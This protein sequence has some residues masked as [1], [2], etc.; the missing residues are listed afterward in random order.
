VFLAMRRL[1]SSSV[2][3]G[4]LPG[5]L[6]LTDAYVGEAFFYHLLRLVYVAAVNDQWG[7]HGL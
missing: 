2:I 6:L 3:V 1:C 7:V 5:C 4:R